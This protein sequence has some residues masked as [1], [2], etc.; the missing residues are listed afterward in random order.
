MQQ[1]PQGSFLRMRGI[2]KIFFAFDFF[3]HIS[4]AFIKPSAANNV[5]PQS[6]PGSYTFASHQTCAFAKSL[7]PA[8]RKNIF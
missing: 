3:R 7:L 5:W 2:S 4:V 1:L 6:A 8:T